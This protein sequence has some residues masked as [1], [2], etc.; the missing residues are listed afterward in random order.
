MLE[1]NIYTINTGDIYI[2]EYSNWQFN[3]DLKKYFEEMET[4][5]LHVLQEKKLPAVSSKTHDVEYFRTKLYQSEGNKIRALDIENSP[6]TFYS[7]QKVGRGGPTIISSTDYTIEEMVE[8]LLNSNS[9]DYLWELYDFSYPYIVSKELLEPRVFEFFFAFKIRQV[10]VMQIDPFLSYHMSQNFDNDKRSYFRFLTLLMRKYQ[11]L[12]DEARMKT[13]D[14]WM[15]KG[16]WSDEAQVTTKKDEDKIKWNGTQ[17]NLAELFIEL[18][19]KGWIDSIEP[20]KIRN[21]FTK[22]KSIPQILKPSFDR[23]T[24]KFIYDQVYDGGYSPKFGKIY[25]PKNRKTS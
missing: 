18:E 6:F 5:I 14:E 1:Q 19:A 9:Q 24:K 23:D 3:P 4:L 22:S 8:E 7:V 20:E 25:F 15:D 17:R 21:A 16:Y 10:D 12:Y 13:I 11:A 2:H